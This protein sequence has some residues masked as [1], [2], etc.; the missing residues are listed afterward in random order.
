[1]V[2]LVLP[3]EH[4]PL[5]LKAQGLQRQAAVQKVLCNVRVTL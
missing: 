3:R 4:V 1:M 2:L 5:V